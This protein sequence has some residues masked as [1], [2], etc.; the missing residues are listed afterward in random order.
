MS[1]NPFELFLKEFPELAQKY[2][3]L[4]DAQ[5]TQRGLDQKTKQLIN[6]AINTA[7]RNPRGVKFHAIMA[8]QAGATR[9]ETL[10]A[11]IMNLHLSGLATVLDSF[12]AAIEGYESKV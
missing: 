1:Q 12:P 4:V 3:Q 5:R 7:L 9:E 8:K 2:N 11:V 6:I 10:G